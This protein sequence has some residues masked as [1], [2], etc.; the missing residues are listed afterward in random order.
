MISP[1]SFSPS[2]S[3]DIEVFYDAYYG[4]GPNQVYLEPHCNGSETSLSDCDYNTPPNSCTHEN[5][6]AIVC[7]PCK[8][9][10]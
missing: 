6:A 2:P 9:K 5:D 1:P 7:T 10:L 4:E 8:K 3:L